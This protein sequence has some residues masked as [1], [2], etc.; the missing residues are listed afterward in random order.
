MLYPSIDSLL[1]RIDSKYSLVTIS[2]QRA[3]ALQ[4]TEE[5]SQ[6]VEKPV[7]RKYV[8]V[9]LEEIEDGYLSIKK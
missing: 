3:R 2:A 1:K 7:S 6:G 4:E 5:G 9:A 8:G